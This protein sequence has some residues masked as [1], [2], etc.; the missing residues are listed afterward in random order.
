VTRCDVSA[1]AEDGL[2]R[3][4]GNAPVVSR[5]K[6]EVI[7]TIGFRGGLLE[8]RYHIM[9]GEQTSGILIAEITRYQAVACRHSTSLMPD[10]A[11]C[12][13]WA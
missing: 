3:K 9:S 12:C 4:R 1:L 7:A 6:C 10:L 2:I 13:T 11:R 5:H 8:F